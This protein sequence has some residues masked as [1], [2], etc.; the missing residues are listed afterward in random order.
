MIADFKGLEN[1]VIVVTDIDEGSLN[2]PE[3]FYVA[4]TRTRY[5]LHVFI[6]SRLRVNLEKNIAENRTKLKGALNES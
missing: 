1:S 2:Q 4:F 6:P 5:S 3:L